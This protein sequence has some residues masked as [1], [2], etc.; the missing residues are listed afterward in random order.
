MDFIQKEVFAEDK[1]L[2]L[3]R[4]DIRLKNSCFLIGH[5]DVQTFPPDSHTI[6]VVQLEQE[7]I[8]LDLFG[9]DVNAFSV[10]D[11]FQLGQ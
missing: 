6:R 4:Y 7:G 1:K 11:S 9:T 8:L 5:E 10:L 3:E 2:L